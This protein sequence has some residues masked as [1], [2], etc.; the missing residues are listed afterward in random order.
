MRKIN[1]VFLTLVIGLWLPAVLIFG[2]LFGCV[3]DAP[4]P[5]KPLTPSAYSTATNIAGT[6][7]TQVAPAVPQ[8]FGAA[9]QGTAAAVLALLAAWQAFT[10]RKLEEIS[11]QT[12]QP[13]K[14]PQT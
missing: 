4:G 5:F 7:S 3:A 14:E 2:S 6:I 9:L 1:P 11:A 13:K 12:A 10:H 8:P